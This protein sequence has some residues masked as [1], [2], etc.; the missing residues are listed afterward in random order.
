MYL[1]TCLN[2]S[3]LLIPREKTKERK[4]IIGRNTERKEE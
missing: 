1:F 3:N 4:Q 2:G